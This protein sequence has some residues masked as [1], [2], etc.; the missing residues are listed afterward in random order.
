MQRK[1]ESIW[2]QEMKWNAIQ[3]KH[4]SKWKKVKKL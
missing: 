1:W 2:K 3:T 4:N